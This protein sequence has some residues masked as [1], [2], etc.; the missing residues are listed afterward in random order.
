[1]KLSKAITKVVVEMKSMANCLKEVEM[2][3]TLTKLTYKLVNSFVGEYKIQKTSFR[4]RQR[5]L[6]GELVAQHVLAVQ[7]E[8]VEVM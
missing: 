2:Q 5:A 1:M 6:T 4:T 3:I 8:V 7:S